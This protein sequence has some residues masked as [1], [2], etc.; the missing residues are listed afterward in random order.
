MSFGLVIVPIS[1]RLTITRDSIKD[2]W[3]H[4]TGFEG[5]GGWPE[6]PDQRTIE[7]PERWVKSVCVLCSTG[8]ALEIGVK[9]G[10]S[11][12][13]AATHATGSTADD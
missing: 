1:R 10:Q 8:C 6:R 11:W 9:H 4:R 2:V 7:E 5:A 13:S 12:V 3:G